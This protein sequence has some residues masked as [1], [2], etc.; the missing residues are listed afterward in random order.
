MKKALTVSALGAAFLLLAGCAEAPSETDTNGV[1]PTDYPIVALCYSSRNTTREELAALAMELCFEG[2]SR[3]EVW[4]HD[5]ILNNCP[6]T[7]KNRVTY[8][9]LAQ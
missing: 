4:D 7:K 5:G 2:T 3:V 9:C 8:R 6:L 1:R